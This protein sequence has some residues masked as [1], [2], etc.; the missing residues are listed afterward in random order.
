MIIVRFQGNLGNQIFQYSMYKKLE[1]MYEGQCVKVDMTIF[2]HDIENPY[3]L[4]KSFEKFPIKKA[5]RREIYKVTHQIP[6]VGLERFCTRGRVWNKTLR[7][8]TWCT[9][10]V[11]NR[12]NTIL[13]KNND[14]EI[15]QDYTDYDKF[16]ERFNHLTAD[17]DWYINGTWYNYNLDDI[18]PKV[19]KLLKFKELDEED[20][21]NQELLK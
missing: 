2:S 12:I 8:V 4:D 15:L 9:N 5:T 13:K 16:D 6:L 3:R 10:V 19:Q 7:K 17:K 20:L 21:K 11:I 14:N 18:R 1:K